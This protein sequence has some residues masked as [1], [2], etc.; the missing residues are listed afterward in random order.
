MNVLEY[1]QESC[2]PSTFFDKF[3][4]GYKFHS[5]DYVEVDKKVDNFANVTAVDIDLAEGRYILAGESDGSIYLYDLFP[6]LSL[7]SDKY[8]KLPLLCQSRGRE[9]K[10]LGVSCLRWF[11]C[12][13]G[14]FFSLQH[15]FEQSRI[16]IWDTNLFAEELVIEYSDTPIYRLAPSPVT[17]VQPLL[18]LSS[19]RK[20]LL[21]DL[22]V[23]QRAVQQLGG[24]DSAVSCVEWCPNVDYCLATATMN[25]DLSLIDWRKPQQHNCLVTMSPYRSASCNHQPTLLESFYQGSECRKP[26]WSPSSTSIHCWDKYMHYRHSILGCKRK[27]QPL[28]LSDDEERIEKLTKPKNEMQSTCEET[29]FAIHHRAHSCCIDFIQFLWNSRYIASLDRQ[30]TIQVWD[31]LTGCLENSLSCS[32]LPNKRKV[33]NSSKWFSI[34]WD[35]KTLFYALDRTVYSFDAIRGYHLTTIPT[36]GT[37]ITA[38]TSHS[39]LPLLVCGSRKGQLLFLGVEDRKYLPQPSEIALCKQRRSFGK[40]L[41]KR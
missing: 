27:P 22:R 2:R 25:G 29:N 28:E 41:W 20:V 31:T 3:Q 24:W 17:C 19:N 33:K 14:M 32:C 26:S 30:G 9:R 37:E 6:Y 1:L 16:G 40:T 39:W 12:D 36:L 8:V 23:G 11:T 7:Q 35:N 21:L 18:A 34:G 15:L 5:L 10:E 13:N 4:V 38:F